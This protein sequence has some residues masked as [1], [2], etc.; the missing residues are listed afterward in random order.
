VRDRLPVLRPGRGLLIAAVTLAFVLA[1][2]GG[3]SSGG[4]S[5]DLTKARFA[6]FGLTFEYPSAWQRENWCW[7][8]NNFFPLTFLTTEQETP[9]CKAS[10][11]PF[12]PGTQLPPPQKI[13]SNGV[14]AWW[15]AANKAG[16]APFKPNTTVDGRPARVTVQQESTRRTSRSYVNCAGSGKTQRLLQALVRGPSEA[17]HEVQLGAVICGP[18]FAA[19]EAEVRKMLASLHFTH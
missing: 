19:G 18:N 10:S 4:G 9:Q 12:T 7:L 15:N 2:C 11:G 6:G 16:S 8:S 1:G 3:G 13:S 14:T 5:S 17:V